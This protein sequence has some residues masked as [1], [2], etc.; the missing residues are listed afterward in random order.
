MKATSLIK[1][2]VSVTLMLL[3]TGCNWIRSISLG[4]HAPIVH[5][6]QQLTLAWD[7][8]LSDSP[9]RPTEVV[10]Y[11]IYYRNHNDFYWRLLSEVKASSHPEYTLKR[12]ELGTGIFDFAVCAIAADGSSSPLHTSL[13]SN[14]DPVSGWYLIWAESD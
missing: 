3:I 6:Y 10:A 9:S 14:A 5:K 4:E 7:P 13:D 2:V 1:L 12:G 11:Q 8:P